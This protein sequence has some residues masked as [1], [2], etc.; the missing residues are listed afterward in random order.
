MFAIEINLKKILQIS[1]KNF[2]KFHYEMK[3]VFHNGKKIYSVL[4]KKNLSKFLH[5]TDIG[6]R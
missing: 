4:L 3:N 2:I 1:L 6:I 5:K